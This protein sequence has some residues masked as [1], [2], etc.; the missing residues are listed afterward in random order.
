MEMEDM[1][2]PGLPEKLGAPKFDGL[3]MFIISIDLSPSKVAIL[4]L[5]SF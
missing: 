4:R 3:S 5:A 2:L 1:G